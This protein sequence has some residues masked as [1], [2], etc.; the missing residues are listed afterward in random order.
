MKVLLITYYWP[1]AG[2][3][4]VQRWLKF[5]KY[6]P[7]FDVTPVVYTVKSPDY[8]IEDESLLSEVPGNIQVIRES[9][10]EPNLILSRFNLKEKQKSVGF[11][12][13]NPSFLGRQIQY[14]RANY[15][16]PDA[17]KFWIKPSVKKLI[18]FV[19][20][21]DIDVIITTGPPHSL[22]MIGA[23]IKKKTGVKWL[24]DFR[25]PW[26]N[27]DYFH[28]LPLTQKAKEKHYKLETMVLKEANAVTVVGNSMKEEFSDRNNHV[29]VLTNGFDDPSKTEEVLLDKEFSICHIGMMNAD[30]NPKVLWQALKELVEASADF[31]KD[32]VVKLIGKCDQEVYQ[33][34]SKAG[35]KSHVSYVDYVPHKEVL[36]FQHAA[37]VLLLA[38]NNVPSAKSLVTGKI[39]EYLQSKRPVIGIGPVDGDLAGILNDTGA[40]QVIDFEDISSLKELIKNYYSLFKKGQLRGESRNI[41][42]YHRKH[43]SR[44]LA[45]ILKS[46]S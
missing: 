15:F 43:L 28:S 18:P 14:V 26:T 34:V 17:R 36:K 24:A 23:E 9:I 25:D 42:R 1:P 21:N 38:V 13:A 8:A 40:G 4:G 29:H 46:L 32:L 30:R 6:L 5:V 2:G 37:Q 39:F 16:I 33:S 12:E 22:H 27:I 31:K 20:E 11:I 3:S 35:L 45:E 41:E 7:S 19:L 44:E 10:W